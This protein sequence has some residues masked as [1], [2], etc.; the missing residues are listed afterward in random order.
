MLFIVGCADVPM[1][2]ILWGTEKRAMKEIVVNIQVISI[3]GR[4]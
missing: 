3:I 1:C 2:R 4:D